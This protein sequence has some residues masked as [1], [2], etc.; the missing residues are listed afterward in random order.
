MRNKSRDQYSIELAQKQALFETFEV[1]LTSKTAKII[2]HNEKTLFSDK[3]FSNIVFPFFKILKNEIEN[4][5]LAVKALRSNDIQ[6]FSFSDKIEDCENCFCTDINSAYLSA[7][8]TLGYISKEIFIKMNKLSKMD[9]LA[10]TGMLATS[11]IVLK[12]ELGELVEASQKEDNSYL[13]SV[14][15]HISKYVGDC[16]L[17]VRNNES[18]NFLFYW[19]D[20]IFSKK[21]LKKSSLKI[22]NDY[23]FDF[24]LE[25]VESLA[26]S[27]ENGYLKIELKKD[28]KKKT[29]FGDKKLVSQY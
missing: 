18:G 12:Y 7:L 21:P 5:G 28:G 11:K 3:S 13:R 6:Y 19:V 1:E 29:F 16:L 24:K 17:D 23:G 25:K 22:F 27:F 8:F 15:F 14:F 10:V 20:G 2:C 4:T 9:R 26:T